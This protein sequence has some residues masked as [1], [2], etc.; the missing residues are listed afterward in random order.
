MYYILR[1][2]NG[3]ILTVDVKGKQYIPVWGSEIGVRRSKRANPDLIVYVPAPLDH[4]LI[5]RK[6]PNPDVPF[7][8]V[9]GR[10][11]DLQTGR[12][13][14]WSELFEEPRLA[15]AA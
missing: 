5:E 15:Q 14:S 4:R 13:I 2:A 6:F 8:L 7:F 10:D 11:P 9:D 12:E 1:K 3:D